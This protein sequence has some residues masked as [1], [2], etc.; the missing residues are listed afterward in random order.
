MP[1]Q[2]EYWM[3]RFEGEVYANGPID[4]RKP[5]TEKQI[6]RY[7]KKR[8]ETDLPFDVWKTTPWWDMTPETHTVTEMSTA[9]LKAME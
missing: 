4:M 8:Y 6:R 9:I 3:Y 7:I 5:V 2:H 1:E